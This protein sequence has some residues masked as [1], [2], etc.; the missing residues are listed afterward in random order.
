M[1]P[2]TSSC[3]GRKRCDLPYKDNTFLSKAREVTK[4][5][6]LWP[7]KLRTVNP[8]PTSGFLTL[9]G[10]PSIFASRGHPVDGK[11][12][13]TPTDSVVRFCQ[14]P[15]ERPVRT[16]REWCRAQDRVADHIKH[17]PQVTQASLMDVMGMVRV[18]VQVYHKPS[19]C[20]CRPFSKIVMMIVYPLLQ[21][22][23]KGRQLSALRHP[24]R[25]SSKKVINIHRS[26]S[27]HL[28]W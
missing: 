17:I 15:G 28:L 12:L 14:R 11:W 18:L 8:P 4:G 16:D 27:P 26:P 13:K 25:G 19:G 20:S 21:L 3:F 5:H 24:I 7:F 9:R 23:L 22:G 2:P 10:R 6:P 1:L